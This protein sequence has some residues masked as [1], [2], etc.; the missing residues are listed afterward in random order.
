MSDTAPLPLLSASP[1]D[2][3]LVRAVQRGETAAFNA[4]LERHLDHLHACI[5]LRLPV[6]H[7]VDELTHETFVFAFRRIADFAPDTSFRAWL[8]AI[9]AHKVLAELERQRRER[10]NHTS[11]LAARTLELAGQESPQQTA[12]EVESLRRCLAELPPHLLDLLER[13]YTAG[14]DSEAIAAQLQRSSAWVRTTLFRTRQ[15]L[16]A[17]LNRQLEGARP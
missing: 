6:P 11:Y 8:R 9:A 10:R 7:L 1:S 4:L 5:A 15:M 14:A 13:K 16:R 17:C 2:A 12:E 3:E